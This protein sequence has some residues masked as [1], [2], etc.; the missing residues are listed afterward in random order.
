MFFTPPVT[1][2]QT[3]TSFFRRGQIIPL[4]PNTIWQI[5][6]GILQLRT[7]N[8]QGDITVLGWL[9]AG[10]FWGDFL[11]Q[12]ETVEAIAF[13]DT[14]LKDYATEQIYASLDLQQYLLRQTLRRL[15]QAEYLLAIAGLKRI[16]SRL[17]SLL[18]FL[19]QE[20]GN[21]KGKMTLIR[22]R[23]THK[24]LADVIGT[25]RV[26]VTRLFKEF[27]TQGWLVLDD[28]RH[29]LIANDYIPEQIF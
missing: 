9:Q 4:Y 25:T 28:D 17:V 13:A 22:Y 16:E 1:A 23:F 19:K 29:L 11:T 14:T 24:N 15:H 2:Q 12:L 5:E 8:D 20:M 10:G 3:A 21:N 27:Q 7:Q 18:F 6:R 26:T